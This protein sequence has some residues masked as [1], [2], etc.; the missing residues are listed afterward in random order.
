MNP[1]LGIVICYSIGLFTYDPS[2]LYIIF[3]FPY[4]SSSFRNVEG[5]MFVYSG[6]RRGSRM[7]ASF[8]E[9]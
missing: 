7:R 9:N 3:H 2:I 4:A 8:R 1:C 5:T 6:G